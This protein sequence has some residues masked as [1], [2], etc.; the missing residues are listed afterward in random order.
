MFS[1]KELSKDTDN[2]KTFQVKRNLMSQF[3]GLLLPPVM[4]MVEAHHL[5]LMNP[6]Y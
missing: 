2:E 4:K 5:L 3:V 1:L 6:Q